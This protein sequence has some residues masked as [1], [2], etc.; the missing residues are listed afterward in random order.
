MGA[1]H[2]V[3]ETWCADRNHELIIRKQRCSSEVKGK[4]SGMRL[5][6][7]VV[8]SFVNWWRNLH[9]VQHKDR[10]PEV[11]QKVCRIAEQMVCIYLRVEPQKEKDLHRVSPQSNAFT[12][13]EI[14]NETTQLKRCSSSETILRR[15]REAQSVRRAQISQNILPSSTKS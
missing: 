4:S 5:I 15:L 10:V 7:G 3:L 6:G 1:I 9:G 11:D 2:K 8:A 13:I 12:A 14:T